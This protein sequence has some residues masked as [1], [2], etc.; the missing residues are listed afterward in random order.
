MISCTPFPDRF[1]LSQVAQPDFGD[2]LV[3]KHSC[4]W[5]CQ[6]VQPSL[7]NISSVPCHIGFDFPRNSF[8][9]RFISWSQLAT[10]CQESDNYLSFENLSAGFTGGTLAIDFLHKEPIPQHD[11]YGSKTPLMICASLGN[12]TPIRLPRPAK[13]FPCDRYGL[14]SP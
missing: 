10:A 12:W 4:P 5:I 9:H 2:C 13:H 11:P 14:S 1:M 3:Y 7:K 6:P 8:W